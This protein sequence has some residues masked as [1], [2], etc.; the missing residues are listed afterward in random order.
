LQ[1]TL[2]L[3]NTYAYNNLI[4]INNK[5]G[6][7]LNPMVTKN[8]LKGFTIV[9]LLIVIVVIGI[10]AAITLVSF[11]GVT[12]RATKA[13]NQSNAQSV[14]SAAEAARGDTTSPCT[15]AYP[16]TSATSATLVGTLNCSVVKV[17]G[18]ITVSSVVPTAST[19]SVL[20]YLV[21]AAATG[22]CVGYWDPTL[23]TPAV[24]FLLSGLATSSTT[25]TC[26]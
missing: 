11:N 8:K 2:A 6:G 18:T 9:E 3:L 10:L 14:I 4:Q 26:T 23:G 13:A 12:Q 16:A 15:G 24:A 19:P 7:K 20:L 21:N 25:T 5:L 22:I 1:K 17:P